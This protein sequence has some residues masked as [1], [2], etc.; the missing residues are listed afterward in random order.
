MNPVE[1]VY[2]VRFFRG[3]H[4]LSWRAPYVCGGIIESLN[5]EKGSSV[6]DVGCA[7]GDL[8]SEFISLGYKAEGIEGSK[9]T[10]AYYMAPAETLTIHDMREYID[11]MDLKVPYDVALCLEVAEHID[12]E[13]AD[14]FVF[15]LCVLS[16][17]IILSAAPPGQ[18]GLGHVNCQMP[19]YWHDK[20]RVNGFSFNLHL[21][22][23]I[24]QKW[25][26]WRKKPG[27]KAYFNNLMVFKKK[28]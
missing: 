26:R 8:V 20:F 7:V 5:L 25:T 16:D 27:I 13:R 22:N 11:V 12:E 15:N 17:L 28:G 4:R 24:K 23:E 14:V 19:E 6:I 3:R 1:D 9:H 10:Q 18:D 21:T 2:G